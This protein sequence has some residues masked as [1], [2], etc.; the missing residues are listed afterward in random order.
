MPIES[1]EVPDGVAPARPPHVVVK[2]LSRTASRPAHVRSRR[3]RVQFGVK[4]MASA[5]LLGACRGRP[6]WGAVTGLV[7]RSPHRSIGRQLSLLL[8]LHR[9]DA[10]Q[11]LLTRRVHR[12]VALR[13]PALV[14]QP[15]QLM[16][17]R[18][19]PFQHAP[20]L[21]LPSDNIRLGP[22]SRHRT[23]SPGGPALGQ[24]LVPL[25]HDVPHIGR[26]LRVAQLA[27]GGA[28]ASVLHDDHHILHALL[29][30]HHLVLTLLRKRLP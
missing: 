5:R 25:R 30:R 8:A 2:I 18:C 14:Q 11:K 28:C 10:T 13:L 1:V 21:A 6:Q 3:P 16:E 15:L 9:Q 17:D 4:A 27:G 7:E 22:C 23:L 20:Q 19:S 29:H 26:E 12:G 24:A